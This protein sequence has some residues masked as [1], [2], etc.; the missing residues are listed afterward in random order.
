MSAREKPYFAADEPAGGWIVRGDSERLWRVQTIK[1][2]TTAPM[3]NNAKVENQSTRPRNGAPHHGH[4][5]ESGWFRFPQFLHTLYLGVGDMVVPG[6][7][8]EIV[9]SLITRNSGL[10]PFVPTRQNS[11]CQKSNQPGSG[12]LRKFNNF[13]GDSG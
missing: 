1:I 8:R 12:I 7:G 13:H 11:D 5:R 6:E 4:C 9:N 2:T 10:P 3:N